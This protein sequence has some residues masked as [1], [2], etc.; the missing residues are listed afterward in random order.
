MNE[1]I[2]PNC[3]KTVEKEDTEFTYDGEAKTFLTIDENADYKLADN[4]AELTQTNAGEYE[5]VVEFT[6]NG[7][8]NKPQNKVIFISF[9]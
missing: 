7:N 8:Y 9:I 2:C 6:V 4:S 1:F 5:A 3:G